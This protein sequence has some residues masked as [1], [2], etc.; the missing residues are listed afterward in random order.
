MPERGQLCWHL[1]DPDQRLGG[2][3]D[4]TGIS[5]TRDLPARAITPSSQVAVV[6]DHRAFEHLLEAAADALDR[7]A[8]TQAREDDDIVPWE[9]VK[10]DLGLT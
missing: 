1:G 4:I 9:Q 3:L 8:L 2:P 5:R 7:A 6:L 10:A